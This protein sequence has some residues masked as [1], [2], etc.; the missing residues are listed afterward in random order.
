MGEITGINDAV[1]Q[2]MLCF[3]SEPENDL[4]GAR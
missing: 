4:G 3:L 1:S 2:P